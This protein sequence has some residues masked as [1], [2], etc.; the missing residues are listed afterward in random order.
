MARQTISGMC[1][2]VVRNCDDQTNVIRIV[3]PGF[4]CCSMQD[5]RVEVSWEEPIK[6][7]CGKMPV[8]SDVSRFDMSDGTTYWL[9]QWGIGHIGVNYCPWCGEKLQ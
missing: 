1:V 5:R 8:G 7:E 9:A 2:S 3:A 4:P 6:H